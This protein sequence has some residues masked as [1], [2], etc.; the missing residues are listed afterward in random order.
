MFTELLAGE[1]VEVYEGSLAVVRHLRRHGVRCA[2]VSSSRS[3]EAI[4][5]AAALAD[6]FEL[7]VDGQIAVRQGLAGKPAPDTFVYA[8]RVLGVARSR[9]VVVEDA[10]AGV[11]AG[12]AGGFCL[13]SGS[14][15]CPPAQSLAVTEL[16]QTQRQ[17][18]SR[19]PRLGRVTTPNRG[20]GRHR[21][22]PI[23]QQSSR[24]AAAEPPA[25]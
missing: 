19:F 8:A 20:D 22:Q 23:D 7:R 5:R 25:L 14:F 2:V 9:A 11:E 4:L 24:R 3:C 18:R 15:C 21:V 16:R 10:I 13:Y 17:R 12:S 6:L 1:G